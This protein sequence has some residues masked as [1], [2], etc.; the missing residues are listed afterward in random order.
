MTDVPTTPAK[1]DSDKKTRFRKLWLVAHRWIGLTVGLLFVL[2]GLT[3]SILVFDHAIDE[4]LNPNLLLTAQTGDQAPIAEIINAAETSYDGKAMSVTKPRVENGV[5]TVWFSKKTKDGRKF[6]AVYVDPTNSKVTGQRTWGEDLLG[7]IYRLHYQLVA[8]Q[9][10]VV[11]VGVAGLLVMVSL[12]SGVYLWWPLW[13]HSWRAAFMIRGGSR[14]NYDL[15][16]TLGIGSFV[17]LFA[18]VFTGV[19]MEFPFLVKPIVTMFSEETQEPR[20]LKSKESESKQA[21]SADDALRIARQHFPNAAFDH[22]HPP[23]GADGTYEVAFRQPHEV[24][25]TFG[26]SQVFLDQYSGE[27][28]ALRNPDDFTAAD[29]FL[30]WQF[31]LHSGE[32]FGMVGRWIVFISGFTPAILYVTGFILWW[33][34]GRSRKKQSQKS[35][36]ATP[37]TSI[38]TET[39]RSPVPVN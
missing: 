4:W 3:G 31:P 30:A 2:I 32:A 25:Q 39:E 21:I 13:K 5:W 34:R 26:R 15:H 24:Q 27:V 29:V 19:Y 23:R 9:T 6:V 8:G 14:F 10:G 17:F 12:I 1:R 22:L 33:R 18:L 28:L 7:W 20:R 37:P 16:K 38:E 35:T 11:I 36:T